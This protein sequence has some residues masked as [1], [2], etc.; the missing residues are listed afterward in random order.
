MGQWEMGKGIDRI[1]AE[2]FHYTPHKAGPDKPKK[3]D[4]SSSQASVASLQRTMQHKPSVWGTHSLVDY[5][6]GGSFCWLPP[7]GFLTFNS[8][9]LLVFTVNSLRGMKH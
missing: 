7:C 5:N 8:M 6:V 9:C 3:S 4:C 1:R 2:E